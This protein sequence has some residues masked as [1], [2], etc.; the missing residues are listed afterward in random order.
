LTMPH[1]MI[2]HA[3]GN[4]RAGLKT[5]HCRKKRYVGPNF[6]NPTQMTCRLKCAP[7][8]RTTRATIGSP[9]GFKER[10]QAMDGCTTRWFRRL[11]GYHWQ[12][13]ELYSGQSLRRLTH[14]QSGYSYYGDATLVRNLARHHHWK[15]TITFL[16]CQPQDSRFAYRP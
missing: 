15:M 14:T 6:G 1:R 16:N 5:P 2:V 3:W 13:T 10:T 12:G 9:S 11:G 4:R 8:L 7:C